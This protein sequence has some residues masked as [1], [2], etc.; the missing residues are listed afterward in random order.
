MIKV[1]KKGYIFLLLIVL[2]LTLGAVLNEE[3]ET[4]A[5]AKNL[6]VKVKIDSKNIAKKI[7]TMNKGTKKKITVHVKPKNVKKSIRYK[8][9]KKAVIKVSKTGKLQAKKRGTAKITVTVTANQKQ[10][11]IWFKVKVVDKKSGEGAAS[12]DAKK[13]ENGGEGTV[14]ENEEKILITVGAKKFKAKLYDNKSAQAWKKM[15][16]MT[17]TMEELNG[18]EKYYYLSSNLPTD[19]KKPDKIHAGDLMLYGSDCLVLFYK[20]F[21]TSY[22]YTSLGYVEDITG[23]EA[24]VG[25]GD[26]KITFEIAE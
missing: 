3:I 26:V 15:L 13:Q 16:P 1:L 2:I 4:K 17:I 8:S 23:L 12:E 9:S 10:K 20:T 5:D 6:S 11:K 24:A 18:N 21:S 19:K 14:K 7:Y 22:S 25:K